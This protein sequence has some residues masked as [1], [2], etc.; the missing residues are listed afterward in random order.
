M[1]GYSPKALHPPAADEIEFSL[2]GPGFGECA[3]CHLGDGEWLVVDSC[4]APET[5][6]PVALDYMRG[7]GLDINRALVCVVATH[8]HDDHIAGLSEILRAAPDAAFAITSAFQNDDFLTALAPWLAD[9]SKLD[10]KG[11]GEFGEIRK[12]KKACRF[13]LEG[14]TLHE[15]AASPHS[16]RIV[17]L[18]PSDMA[19]A[20]SVAGLAELSVGTFSTRLPNLKGNPSS[21]V[22]AVETGG[23]RLLLGGDLQ[24]RADRR[25]GWLAVVDH[26]LRGQ[27]PKYHA[28]KIPHHGSE[29]ADHPEIW[30]HL[31]EENPH[32]VLAPFVGGR[33]KLPTPEDL[34]RIKGRTTRASIT[35]LPTAGKF[36]HPD[37]SVERTMQNASRHLEVIPHRFGH[38]RMRGK[39]SESDEQWAVEHFGD[40]QFV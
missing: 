16:C 20:T 3:V 23:R 36:K 29:N 17:A 21:M 14:R 5:R 15:R 32:A 34:A 33:T 28:Y 27:R 7:M 18:A 31:M 8:W 1:I 30:Q 9:A 37:R 2:F 11:L 12:L 19:L 13:A 38:V 24:L 6:N 25:L 35:A 22:L 39:L 40:A 26:H 4:R 10:G